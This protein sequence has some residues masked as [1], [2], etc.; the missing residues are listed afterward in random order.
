MIVDSVVGKMRLEIQWNGVEKAID[1]LWWKCGMMCKNPYW[2]QEKNQNDEAEEWIVAG[3]LNS[4]KA[5]AH[6]QKE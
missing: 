2:G 1:K 3:E 4:E 5:M 6:L